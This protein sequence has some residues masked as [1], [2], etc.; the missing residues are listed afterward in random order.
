VVHFVWPASFVAMLYMD[1]TPIRDPSYVES[2]FSIPTSREKALG[3]P[4]HVNNI[5][6]FVHCD[7]LRCINL[8]LSEQFRS[9]SS[10]EVVTICHFPLVLSA[11][12]RNLIEYFGSE[13]R[14][15]PRSLWKKFASLLH[16]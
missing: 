14:R 10:L 12:Q 1:V 5:Y 13:N 15:S 16:V 2:N 3:A 4:F 6:G 7:V 9:M 8:A 11:T